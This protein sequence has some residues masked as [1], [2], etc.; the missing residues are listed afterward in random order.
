M[1]ELEQIAEHIGRGQRLQELRQ[2]KGWQDVEQILSSIYEAAVAQALNNSVTDPT[3]KLANLA[4]AAAIKE[5]RDKFLTLI[6]ELI[7]HSKQLQSQTF[8]SQHSY[9]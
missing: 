5:V 6:D 1:T 7:D 3:Q 9:F 2:N 4:H 8:G